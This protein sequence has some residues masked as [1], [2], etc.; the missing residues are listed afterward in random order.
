MAEKARRIE[1]RTGGGEVILSLIFIEK[2]I[3][4]EK[5]N[6]NGITLDRL[7]RILEAD[8]YA[9]KVDTKIHYKEGETEMNLMVMAKELLSQYLSE[10]LKA[11]MGSEIPFTIPLV[12]PVTGE[13]LNIN[14]EGYIDLVEKDETIVE[15]KTS[16]QTM[17]QKSVD[18]HLQLTA[19]S[20]AFE[21]L[22][23]RPPKGLRIVN[24]VKNKKPKVVPFETQRSPADYQRFFYLAGQI[25][26]GIES[27][28]FFPRASFMCKDCEFAAPCRKWQGD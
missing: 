25:L 15:F 27:Q 2:E 26:K 8:W 4:K 28:V 1:L 5:I 20:Y 22:H 23:R 21:M 3:S 13:S 9:Q 6:G 12:N 14:L 16:N 24:F 11:V 10:P 17:D 7:Y 18:D 19:Y